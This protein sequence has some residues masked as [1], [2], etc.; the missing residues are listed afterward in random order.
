MKP[1]KSAS[2]GSSAEK[3][4]MTTSGNIPPKHHLNPTEVFHAHKTSSQKALPVYGIYKRQLAKCHLHRLRR[5]SPFRPYLLWLSADSRCKR[6]T[7]S[8]PNKPPAGADKGSLIWVSGSLELETF[9]KRDGI[10]TDKRLKI[11]LD[12]WGFI[13]AHASKERPRSAEQTSPE[14][15]APPKASEIDGDREPL[16]V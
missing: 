12:N 13:P 1:C 7:G 5:L 11:L 10:T 8:F 3:T 9:T 14:P 15:P 6:E 2:G 4:I 16:P